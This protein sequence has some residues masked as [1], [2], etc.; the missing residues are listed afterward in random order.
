[1]MAAFRRYLIAGLLVWVPLVATILVI[2][3]L[4]DI[5]D[6]TLLLLPEA[7]R[8]EALIGF[9]I[10]G[11]GVLLTLVVVLGT[12]AL[13]A[14][15][16]GRR[17]VDIG[18]ALLGRIPLVRSIYA[19]VKQVMETVFSSKGQSFRKVLMI[20][21]PLQGSWTLAFQTGVTVGEAQAKTGEEVINVFVPFTPIPTTGYFLMVARKDVVELDM[22][23]DEGL[24][25]L[26]S[27]G[28]VVPPWDPNA[29][30]R[31]ARTAPPAPQAPR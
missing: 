26:L 3:F 23:V 17:L 24:K 28:V 2:G 29:P 31:A 27:M 20:Q 15:L 8:P 5:M 10:P 30:P 22:S 13:A 25:M 7:F 16:L 21:F 14:N 11:L 19:S 1:M 9:R 4:V 18:E 6:R 12:G